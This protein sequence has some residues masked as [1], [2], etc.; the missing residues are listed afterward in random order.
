MSC[1]KI[2]IIVMFNKISLRADDHSPRIFTAF[3]RFSF[4][5]S[6]FFLD[7]Q[8][9]CFNR[10]FSP[11]WPAS[12][13]IYWNKRECSHKKRVQLPQDWF[14]RQ[15]WPPFHCF[16]TPIWPSSHHVKTLYC[17]VVVV[18]DGGLNLNSLA[19]RVFFKITL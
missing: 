8:D 18:L 1:H 19:D 14:G 6:F 4:F 12:M 11:T 15:T 3:Y 10:V 9:F 2:K 17:F 16:G 7:A 13:Q 5:T